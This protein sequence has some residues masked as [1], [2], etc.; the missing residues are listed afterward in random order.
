[1]G[2]DWREFQELI[3]DLEDVPETA[4]KY[5]RKAVQVTATKVKDH[6]RDQAKGLP[7][8][9][10]FPFSITYDLKGFQGFG[11]TVL[12]AEIGPDKGRR[13]GALG[14][15]IEFGSVNNAP[16]GLGQ[17]ALNANEADFATGIEKAIADAHREK[18]L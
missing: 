18:N 3:Q 1:M 6:W 2:V 9:P 10:A 8:A 7:H 11:S 16:Q 17:A 4:G 14:N 15:L 13:Q 5:I 12:S